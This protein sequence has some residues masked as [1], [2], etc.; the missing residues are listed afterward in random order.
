MKQ[1]T[2]NRTLS[3]PSDAGTQISQSPET[4][5]ESASAPSD[6]P[7]EGDDFVHIMETDEDLEMQ[8][9]WQIRHMAI[10]MNQYLSFLRNALRQGDDPKELMKRMKIIETDPDDRSTAFWCLVAMRDRLLTDAREIAKMIDTLEKERIRMDTGSWIA[11]SVSAVVSFLALGRLSLVPWGVYGFYKYIKFAT[12]GGYQKTLRHVVDQLLNW[13]FG[14]K[15]RYEMQMRQFDMC[16]LLD[17]M[18]GI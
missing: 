1:Q 16:E 6:T 10:H 15:D 5:S 2:Q 14:D 11:V 7:T 9:Q 12:I 3:S 4:P 18:I 13:E 17:K 8:L